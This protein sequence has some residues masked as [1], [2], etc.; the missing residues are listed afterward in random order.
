MA[1]GGQIVDFIGANLADDGHQA[2]GISQIPIVEMEIL[3]PLQMGDTL[4]V[5]HRGTANHAMD[6][7]SFFQKQFCQIAAVLAGHAGNQSFFH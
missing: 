3:V 6:I 2:H 4:P 5:I 1:L 7:I